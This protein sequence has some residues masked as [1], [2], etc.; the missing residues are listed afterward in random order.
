M[1]SFVR[2]CGFAIRMSQRI[3]SSEHIPFQNMV[4]SKYLTLKETAAKYI[5][6]Q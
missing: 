3:I 1:S 2:L 5:E 4:E 6:E